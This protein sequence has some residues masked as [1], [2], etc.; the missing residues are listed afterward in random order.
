[1]G[2]NGYEGNDSVRTFTRTE[3][4][5]ILGEVGFSHTFFYYPYPDYKFPNEIFTDE[6]LETNH[7]GRPI[8]NIEDGRYC[9]FN[10]NTVGD[11]LLHEHVRGVFANSFLVEASRSAFESQVSYAKLNMERNRSFRTGTVIQRKGGTKEVVKFP[12]DE[13]ADSHI[14]N[15]YHT[16]QQHNG[17]EISY[18]PAEKREREIVF[19]FL[20]QQNLDGKIGECIETGRSDEIVAIL[21]GFFACYL[22]ELKDRKKTAEYRTEEFQTVFGPQKDGKAY[23]C[24]KNA[25]IDVIMDNIYEQDG[26]YV[27]I[28]GEWIYDGWLPY[29]FLIWR[30][31]NEL[32]ARHAALGKLIERMHLMEHFEIKEEDEVLFR[33]WAEYF[34]Q[35]YVGSGQRINWA[36]EMKP[37]SLDAIHQQEIRKEFCT[38]SLY[39]DYGDGFSEEGKKWQDVM[40]KDGNFE[41]VFLLEDVKNVKALRFDPIEGSICRCI[42]DEISEGYYLAGNNA[43]DIRLG[44]D[45]FVHPDPQYFIKTDHTTQKLMIRGYLHVLR[46]EEIMTECRRLNQLYQMRIDFA[47]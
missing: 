42:I 7:Y 30:S 35:T 17:A 33:A 12:L 39:I 29:V 38:M 19:P 10:E 9:L 47:R 32:Y 21:D 8:I 31:I 37:I 43:D 1:L 14:C 18:L 44:Q 15:I 28:D 24:V 27:L 22:Q 46:E 2:L 23:L 16:T 3:L 26:N 45:L 13:L 34:A 20:T 6:T 11:F 36:K 25:N 41:V 5:D 40:L 4:T